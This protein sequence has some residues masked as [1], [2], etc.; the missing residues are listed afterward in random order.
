MNKE[1]VKFHMLCVG[2]NTG[3]WDNAASVEDQQLCTFWTTMKRAENYTGSA[4]DLD[5]MQDGQQVWNCQSI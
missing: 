5:D 2:I 1:Q 4:H 3:L